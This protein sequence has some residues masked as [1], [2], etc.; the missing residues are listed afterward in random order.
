MRIKAE[1]NLEDLNKQYRTVK[2]AFVERDQMMIA[3]RK[4]YETE[5]R[6]LIEMERICDNLKILKESLEKQNAI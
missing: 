4:K 3:Y 2:D 1:E 5:S 6:K